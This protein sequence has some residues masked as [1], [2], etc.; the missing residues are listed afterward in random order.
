MCEGRLEERK[1]ADIVAMVA[2][3]GDAQA[4]EVVDQVLDATFPRQA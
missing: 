1:A 3:L 4:R 2:D